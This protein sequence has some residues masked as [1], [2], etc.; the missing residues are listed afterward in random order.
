M[1]ILMVVLG[2]LALW[3]VAASVVAVRRDGYGRVG[4]RP[5]QDGRIPTRPS[6]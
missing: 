2:G 1:E 6:C 3:A 5:Q 4:M